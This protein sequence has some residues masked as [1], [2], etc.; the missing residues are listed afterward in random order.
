MKDYES[1]LTGI[2]TKR[3]PDCLSILGDLLEAGLR[4]GHCS[5][6]DVRDRDFE[7]PNIIGS[8]FKLLPGLGFKCNEGRRI[9]LKAEKKHSR[10]V[11]V[12]E[13]VE[14]SRAEQALKKIRGII[15]PQDEDKDGQLVLL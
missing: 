15:M 10:R 6:A 3:T 2:I 8:S 11:P 13:L 9:T 12:W 5:A 1:W 4:Q 14:A 7:Q